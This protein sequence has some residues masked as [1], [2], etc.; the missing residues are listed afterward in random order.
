M[1][2]RLREDRGFSD[3]DSDASVFRIGSWQLSHWRALALAASVVGVALVGSMAWY[4][5]FGGGSS[6]VAYAPDAP[7]ATTQSAARNERSLMDSEG[8]P[9]A[10]DNLRPM[11][12]ANLAHDQYGAGQANLL[13]EGLPAHQVVLR[14]S[15]LHRKLPLLTRL[16]ILNRSHLS[17]NHWYS[18]V[19]QWRRAAMPNTSTTPSSDT[20]DFARGINPPNLA[21]PAQEPSTAGALSQGLPESTLAKND[22]AGAMGSTGLSM[23]D[24]FPGEAQVDAKGSIADSQQ[25]SI[26]GNG[27]L[28]LTP[29]APS[30]SNVRSELP[31]PKFGEQAQQMM[32]KQNPH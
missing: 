4:G 12:S 7:G 2:E 18:Q 6:S 27:S 19:P 24:K 5:V 23:S 3:S 10:A 16:H 11:A 15:Q 17:S 25:P 1:T 31:E 8:G 26:F 13:E 9:S 22:P 21:A 14:P 28:N 32:Q 30:P 29:G 20:K